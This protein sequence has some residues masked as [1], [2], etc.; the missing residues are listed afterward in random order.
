MV[1]ARLVAP[2][3][4]ELEETPIPEPG[5]GEVRFRLE[6]CGVCASNIPPYEGREWFS[7][8]MAP[9]A[10]GH[11]GWGVVDAVGEGVREVRPGDRVAALSQH[12]YAEYDVAPADAVVRLA[13]GL[14]GRPFPGEPLGCAHNIFSRSG[15]RPGDTV[16][17]V[18]IGFLGTLLTMMAAEAGAR[19]VAIGRRPF[20]LRL[21][22]EMG[23]EETIEMDDHW[24]IV[25]LVKGLTGDRLAEVV[26]ECVGKQWPLDLAGDLCRERGRLV[27]AGYHQDGLRQ[28]NMQMW[29]WKGLDVINAHEREQAAYV[30]GIRA[31]MERVELG[32]LDPDPLYTHRYPL[33]DLGHALEDTISRPEGFM[34]AL[35]TMESRT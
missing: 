34:K 31:A 15:V 11:E 5:P 6:G 3:R 33:A 27:V 17:I 29:N 30:E 7:Y 26:I 28:V 12:A 8:P 25:D 10:L 13:P 9:G 4:F 32:G 2:R 20:A 23:A 24:R 1:A 18:G 16:A 19:V 35:V 22:R 21:A 14:E